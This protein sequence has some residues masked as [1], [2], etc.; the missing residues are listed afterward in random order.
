MHLLTANQIRQWDQYTIE[1]EPITSTNLMERAAATFVEWFMTVYP[2]TSS[3]IDIVCGNGNN[4]GDGL[5]AA[6][7]LRNAFYDVNVYIIRCTDH[8]SPDFT[9]HL[10]RLSTLGDVPIVWTADDVQ[11]LRK[12]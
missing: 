2:D 12:K 9:T 3:P 8:D 10:N 1:H 6:R 4:G 7:L 5:V 11:S